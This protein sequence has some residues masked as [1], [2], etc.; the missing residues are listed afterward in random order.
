MEKKVQRTAPGHSKQ[1]IP[2]E[3]KHVE[4]GLLKN[5]VADAMN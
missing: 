5:N 1:A 3:G 2:E 4:T